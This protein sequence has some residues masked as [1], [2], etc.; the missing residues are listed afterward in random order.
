M[1]Q[2]NK[3]EI[4]KEYILKDR[5]RFSLALDIHDNF[6]KTMECLKDLI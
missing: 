6:A 2:M 1:T 3:L 5:N 4:I